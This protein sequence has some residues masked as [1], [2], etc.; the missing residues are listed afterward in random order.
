MSQAVQSVSTSVKVRF[1]RELLVTLDEWAIVHQ[2]PRSRAVR[3]LMLR[4]L[5]LTKPPEPL[6]KG[7][8]DC[9]GGPDT[10][11]GNCRQGGG[12]T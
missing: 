12:R 4:G 8:C 11:T 9:I 7:E 3:I 5:W 6:S 2:V 1:P 10:C